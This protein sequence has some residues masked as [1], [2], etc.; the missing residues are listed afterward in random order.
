[1]PSPKHE[2]D[3]APL[4]PG[5]EEWEDHRAVL[6]DCAKT[7]REDFGFTE[8]QYK[9]L[10][11]LLGAVQVGHSPTAISRFTGL[12]TGFIRRRKQKLL[13][14]GIWMDDGNTTDCQWFKEHG[15]M[16]L[17]LDV[18]VLE[19]RVERVPAEPGKLHEEWQGAKGAG[20]PAIQKIGNIHIF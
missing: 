20:T 9:N 10:L 12:A 17:V 13:D 3:T 5:S 14:A 16:A 15:E 4:E 1:M 8:V 18:L 6:F 19:G 2:L 7:I 11:L